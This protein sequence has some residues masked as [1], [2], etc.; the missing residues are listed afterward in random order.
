MRLALPG[1]VLV[2]LV[3]AGAVLRYY[4]LSREHPEAGRAFQALLALSVLV[5]AVFTVGLLVV[6]RRD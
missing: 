2:F 3:G 5:L 4:E 1:A 6:L